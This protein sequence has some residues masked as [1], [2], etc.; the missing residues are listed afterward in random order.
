[1]TQ[2][3]LLLIYSLLPPVAETLFISEESCIIKTK[4]L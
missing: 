2:S 3:G 1:M 4:E